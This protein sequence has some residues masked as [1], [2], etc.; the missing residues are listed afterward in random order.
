MKISQSTQAVL[1]NFASINGQI[2]IEAGTVLYSVS[3]CGILAEAVVTEHFP[4]ECGIF[5]LPKFLSVLAM[6]RTPDCDFQDNFVMIRDADGGSE[7]R[8]LY[9]DPCCIKPKRPKRLIDLPNPAIAFKL[10]EEKW[11]EV[12]KA[13]MILAKPEIRIVSDGCT[14]WIKTHDSKYPGGSE[15]STSL[16]GDPGGIRCDIIFQI[17]NLKLLTGSYKGVAGPSFTVFTNSS[18]YDLTYWVACDPM[19]EFGAERLTDSDFAKRKAIPAEECHA[20]NGRRN[21][22]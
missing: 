14:I 3:S 9:A 16:P 20:N 5:D 17:A 2:L 4:V 10:P 15:F 13:G 18:G 22:S 12:Q 7:V 1:K 11:A 21:N 6:Y 8:Y 19:S